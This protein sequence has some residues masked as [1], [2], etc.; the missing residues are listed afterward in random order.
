MLRGVLG[1]LSGI[2]LINSFTTY[3]GAGVGL[4]LIAADQ[5]TP[6]DLAFRNT[7][8]GVFGVVVA[9]LMLCLAFLLLAEFLQKKIHFTKIL[10]AVV[11][12]LVIV[13]S[14]IHIAAYLGLGKI[15]DADL[16]KFIDG[17]VLYA[18]QALASLALFVIVHRMTPQAPSQQTAD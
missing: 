8:L 4:L 6:Q 14:L 5:H 12:P 11:V 17:F 15:Q 13:F 1:V 2:L 10:S 3:G 9:T 18:V 16:G 7:V